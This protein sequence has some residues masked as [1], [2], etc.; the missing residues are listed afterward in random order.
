MV[1]SSVLSAKPVAA[2]TGAILTGV[3]LTRFVAVVLSAKETMLNAMAIIQPINKFKWNSAVGGVTG[4]KEIVMS[5]SYECWA[6][7]NGKADKM[8]KVTANN[9]NEAEMKAWEKFDNLG[10]RPERVTCK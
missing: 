10:I 6:Y 9:R 4:H 3:F 5:M 2:P 8:V 1:Q 7:K